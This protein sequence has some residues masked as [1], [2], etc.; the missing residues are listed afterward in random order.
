MNQQYCIYTM[1]PKFRDVVKYISENKLEYSAHLN[2]T[3]F[4][5]PTHQL[6]EF[7]NQFGAHC[8]YVPDG[9][10][11]ATGQNLDEW[12]QWKSNKDLL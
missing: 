10:D 1:S 2:R 8:D 3:R 6:S 4:W 7:L 11:Y 5:V 9:Q 12:D